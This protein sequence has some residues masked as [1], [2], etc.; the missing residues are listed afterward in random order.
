MRAILALAMKDLRVLARIRSALVFTILWPLVVAVFFGTIFSGPGGQTSK[1]PVVVV[2]RDGT[3][4]SGEFVQ[5]LER[6]GELA[7][8]RGTEDEAAALVRQG[9]KTAALVLLPGFGAASRRM[10]YGEPPGIEVWLDPSRQAEAAMV[11]GILLKHAAERMQTAMADTSRSRSMVQEALRNLDEA[12]PG[13]EP[14]QAE[15]TRYLKELE[16]FLGSQSRAQGTATG[17]GNWRPLDVSIREI[18]RSWS[19]PRNP[20]DVTFP[21]GILWGIIGATMAFGISIVSERTQGTFVRL[22]MS[23]LTRFQI[24]AGKAVACFASIVAL[25]L[26]IILVGIAFFRIRPASPALLALAGL[27]SAAA[28]VGIMMLAAAAGKT[29]Q[30]AAGVGWAVMLPLAMLGGGM[31]PLFLM[32]SWLVPVSRVSPVRWAILAIEGAVWRGFSF[33]EMLLPCGT[34]LVIGA[35]CFAAGTR[36]LRTD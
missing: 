1:V 35:V 14:G 6:S 2:D 17:S 18:R 26:L 27:S 13:T 3:P 5:R 21:Q 10:F 25:E 4:E 28:F 12:P 30:A 34:L 36:L 23:P 9:R 33:Q 24:L 32:P 22:R 16:L 19:G 31:I 8:S 15:L 7:V 20:F 29:E 11:Q